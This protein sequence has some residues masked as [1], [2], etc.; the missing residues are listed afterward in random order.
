M[1]KLL[2]YLTTCVIGHEQ[3]I[4]QT[5]KKFSKRRSSHRSKWNRLNCKNDKDG[6]ALSRHYSVF[7]GI[8]NK[9]PTVYMKLTLLLLLSNLISIIWITV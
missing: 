6:V 3:Y 4:G 5:M 9:P 8:V 1:R 7:H 2:W